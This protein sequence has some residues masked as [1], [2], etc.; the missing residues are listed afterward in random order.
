MPSRE[1]IG[2][3]LR[4]MRAYGF[5]P[6]GSAKGVRTF[7][8]VLDC[9]GGGIKVSL[10]LS[11]WNFHQYPEIRVLETPADLPDLLPHLDRQGCLCYFSPGSVVLDRY[12]PATS[13]AQC[14]VQATKVLGDIR[15]D[16]AY[17]AGDV[18]D[19]FENHWLA[20]GDG[21]PVRVLL[22]TVDPATTRSNYFVFTAAEGEIIVV[23]DDRAEAQKLAK[24][25][26]G[27]PAINVPM[28]CWIFKTDVPQLVPAS[29]PLT[30]G[31]LFVWL[32]AWDSKLFNAVQRVL[33]KEADYLKFSS[34]HFAIR[35]RDTWLGFCFELDQYTRLCS[36]KRPALYKQYLHRSGAKTPITRLE[37]VE[38][39][40]QFVHSRN[41]TYPDLSG[42][43][44]T[45]IGCGAIGSF[46]AES[47]ARLGA[48]AGGG[49][50]R[51][52]DGDALRPENLGRHLL[53]YP[54][55]FRNKATELAREI[56]SKFPLAEVVAVPKDATETMSFGRAHLV[57]DATGEES[58]S[59]MLN[60]MRLARGKDAPPILHVRIRGNGECVQTFWA[61]G[62]DD[63]CLR[64]LISTE[65]GEHRKE[66]FEVLNA[67]PIRR[68]RGCTGFTPYS[69]AAPMAAAAL[70]I[71]VIVDWLQRK[72]PH[73]R[74]RTR[75]IANADVRKI[76]DKTVDRN[77]KCPACGRD[78][79]SRQPVL[80]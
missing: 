76:K 43:Q 17:R 5:Q 64:C 52:V 40:P 14:L 68:R 27:K 19:E 41:L 33:E 79:D 35:C 56:T 4:T 8:G 25:M 78:H 67:Q 38:L 59:E 48:G 58:V 7:T 53:G 34:A 6:T 72:S 22:G 49:E 63:A 54:S 39:G 1:Q 77:P 69:V 16:P 62:V 57:I 13:V 66:R 46:L 29:M 2:E 21:D 73:P 60:A 47:A 31:E 28:P 70:A 80:A 9:K 32:K 12:D 55:L 26:T 10:A 75:A 45:I 18:Q 44:I 51:V 30:V 11:D 50:L 74:F 42:R 61:E 3:T 23:A 20:A 24:A 71:E 15:H 37:L 36:L 65:P